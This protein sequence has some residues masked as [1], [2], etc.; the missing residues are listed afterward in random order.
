MPERNP[1][2]DHTTT[3]WRWVQRCAPELSRR[4]L[5]E[6]KATGGSWQVDETYVY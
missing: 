6:L 3:V 5:R 2:V 1:A 4:V